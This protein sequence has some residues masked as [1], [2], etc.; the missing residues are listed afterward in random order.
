M[1]YAPRR[2]ITRTIFGV[3]LVAAALLTVT[4]GTASADVEKKL[5]LYTASFPGFAGAAEPNPGILV[6]LARIAAEKTG[7]SLEQ[8]VVPWARAIKLARTEDNVLISG[9]T[10]LE[11]RENNFSW[12]V[13]QLTLKNAF[14]S[15]DR[16]VNSYEEAR[17]LSAIGVHRATSYEVEL[18]E[19]G[20]EN[21]RSFSNPDR[22]IKFFDGGRIDA[23][24]GSIHEFTKRLQILSPEK[25]KR[26]IIGEPIL[27]EELWLAGPKHLSPKII[28]DLN[29]GTRLAIEEGHRD[30]LMKKYFGDLQ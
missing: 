1:T 3:G 4:A 29:Y 2:L 5:T 6:E 21:I 13:R 24:F 18:E 7:Y 9:F 30:R 25:R 11:S 16:A 8:K 14:I 10:R 28:E 26:F 27:T 20:F 12:I 22:I 19:R 15:L 17:K 23:W